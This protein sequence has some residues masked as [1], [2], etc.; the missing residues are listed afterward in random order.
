MELHAGVSS[1]MVSLALSMSA[2]EVSPLSTASCQTF[3]N[4]SNPAARCPL[5]LPLQHDLLVC[6]MDWH[7]V[8]NKLVTC[9][10]DRSAFVW[11]YNAAKDSWD[12]T[13]TLL[14]TKR[15]ALD[16]K[17]SPNGKKFAV[18]SSS[19]QVL[20]CWYDPSGKWYI[21]KALKKCKSTVVAVAW[22]PNSQI[23]AAASTDYKCRV[24]SA[25]I[26]GED[27]TPDGA[28]FGSL[29]EAGEVLVDFE[30]TK[31]WVNDCAWSPSGSQLAFIAHD[32]LLHIANFAAGEGQNPLQTIKTTALP[33]TKVLFLSESALA[34][35]GHSMNVDIYSKEGSGSGAWAFKTSLDKKAGGGAAAGGAGAAERPGFGAAKAVFAAMVFKGQSAQ[36]ASETDLWTKHQAAITNLLPYSVAG[37]AAGGK[38]TKVSTSGLDGRVV[39]WDVPL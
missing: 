13:V 28:Q 36:A 16:V 18:A 14:S 23:L 5:S 37:G 31:S 2:A 27:E 26:D 19:K 35:A 22:H 6:A 20:V 29:P 11:E 17:W 25:F 24:I 34:T 32:G 39:C 15:A 30:Q 7:P 1:K 21:S 3:H 4:F 38:V 12:P 8:T 33:A 10:H 9:S